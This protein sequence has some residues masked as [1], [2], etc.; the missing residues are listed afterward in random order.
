MALDSPDSWRLIGRMVSQEKRPVPECVIADISAGTAEP[1]KMNCPV[2]PRWLTVKRAA[3]QRVGASCHSSI[4]LGTFPSR[5]ISG[6]V[7]ASIRLAFM[8][9]GASKNKLLAAA[10]CAVVVF[11]HHLG[12]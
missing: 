1:V 9:E 4:N 5:I 8:V 6:L 10:C 3:S 2:F 12:P 11:P 7:S